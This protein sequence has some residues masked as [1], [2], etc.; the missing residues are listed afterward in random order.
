MV[1]VR[2][3]RAVERL[4]KHPL[5]GPLGTVEGTREV[6]VPGLPYVIVYRVTENEVEILRVWHARQDFH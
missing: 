2:I 6:V 5:S 3:E 1:V 4:A